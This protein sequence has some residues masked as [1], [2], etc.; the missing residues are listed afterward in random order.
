[1]KYLLNLISNKKIGTI[2]YNDFI[3]YCINNQLKSQL[4]DFEKNSLED[5]IYSHRNT[6]LLLNFYDKPLFEK[7][8]NFN[9]KIHIG[10]IGMIKPLNIYVKD[11]TVEE[12]KYLD[13]M[14]F[15]NFSYDVENEKDYKEYIIH[16]ILN[17]N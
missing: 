13:I 5:I 6:H 12:N 17:K 15:I 4:I 16:K 7:L 10:S 2:A 1:M 11:K 9:R 14:E 8:Y 3:K